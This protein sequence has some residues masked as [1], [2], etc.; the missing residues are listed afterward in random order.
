MSS[1]TSTPADPSATTSLPVWV[2]GRLLPA[3]EARVRATDHGLVAGGGVFESLKVT[4]RGAFAVT[5]H[6]AR[7][8]R[9]AEALGLPEPD[10]DVVREAIDAVVAE[11]DYDFGLLRITWT[12]GAGPLGSGRAFGPPTLVVAHA[13]VPQPPE[14]TAVVT[15]PW[16]RNEH[17]AMTGVKTTSY[18][19]NIRGLAFAAEHGASEGIFLNTAGRVCEGTGANL[20]WVVDGEVVTSPLS[21]G[22]LAGV[23]RALVMEWADV[24]ERDVTLAEAQAA[25]EVFLTSSTRDVQRVVRWDAGEYPADGPVTT[26]LRQVFAERSA[27]DWDPR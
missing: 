8:S 13:A 16:S 20:F 15:L 9:S 12:G 6:L 11:R 19:E 27:A 4:E 2:S 7:L 18:G 22:A 25:Q 5:R 14:S 1:R 17:G 26:R 10:H 21:S 3:D 23:T 24:V